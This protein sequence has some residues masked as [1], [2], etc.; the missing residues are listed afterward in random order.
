LKAGRKPEYGKN[1][2]ELPENITRLVLD[3]NEAA[4]QNTESKS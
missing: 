1:N 4:L 3:A 2:E